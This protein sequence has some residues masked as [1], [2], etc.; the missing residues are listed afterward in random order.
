MSVW[1]GYQLFCQRNTD[2]CIMR[3]RD[4]TLPRSADQCFNSL[5][6]LGNLGSRNLQN[7]KKLKKSL[8][9]GNL[10]RDSGDLERFISHA[11]GLGVGLG[12]GEASGSCS[13]PRRRLLR[14]LRHC[15][16]ITLSCG[17][18]GLLAFAD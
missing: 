13:A 8:L 7:R 10:P 11:A 18:L 3:T 4:L 2:N 6:M 1:L 15:T 12:S 9:A 17:P 5:R 16:I 14:G